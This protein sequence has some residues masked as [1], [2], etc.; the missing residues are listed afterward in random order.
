[1][2]HQLNS[3]QLASAFLLYSHAKLETRPFEQYCAHRHKYQTASISRTSCGA[4][5]TGLSYVVT[6]SRH[7]IANLHA[8][9]PTPEVSMYIGSTYFASFWDFIC[10]RVLSCTVTEPLAN[11]YCGCPRERAEGMSVSGVLM[12]KLKARRAEIVTWQPNIRCKMVLTG[13]YFYN[14]KSTITEI[15]LVLTQ[16]LLACT[17]SGMTSKPAN[18]CAVQDLPFAC[19]TPRQEIWGA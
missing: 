6:W 2:S 7:S 8:H 16:E 18:T 10:T 9:V 15:H 13:V 1:M 17:N 3:A 12:L 19:I 5:K 14:V 11:T 4:L